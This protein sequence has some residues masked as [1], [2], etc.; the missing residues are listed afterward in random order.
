MRTSM[1]MLTNLVLLLG[2]I[3]SRWW[4][5]VYNVN[6]NQKDLFTTMLYD[7]GQSCILNIHLDIV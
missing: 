2:L 3:G 5:T 7:Q 1:W 4:K 6:D